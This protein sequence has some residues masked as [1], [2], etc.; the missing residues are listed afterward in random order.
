MVAK[1]VVYPALFT[2]STAKK[3]KGWLD[4]SVTVLDGV[5]VLKDEDGNEMSRTKLGSHETIKVW[6]S[7]PTSIA[8]QAPKHSDGVDMALRATQF[9]YKFCC[10]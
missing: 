3:K 4:G 1:G 8:S 6:M 10:R 5:I 2:K 7:G 9:W